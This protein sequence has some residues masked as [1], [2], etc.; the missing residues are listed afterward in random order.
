MNEEE[1][2]TE[3]LTGVDGF[4]DK[5][6]EATEIISGKLIEVAPDAANA[7]LNLVQ[8][9]GIFNLIVPSLFFFTFLFLVINGLKWLTEVDDLEDD[10]NCVR[11][12]VQGITCFITGI[13]SLLWAVP[14]MLSFYN[15]LSALYPEGAIAFKALQAV[16]IDL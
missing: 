12:F 4:F 16:G 15:W 14:N 10:A 13:F 5:L 8:F 1:I 2:T 9:K 6:T 7:L 11:L 3:I